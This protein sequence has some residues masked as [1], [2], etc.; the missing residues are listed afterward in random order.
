MARHSIRCE[1]LLERCAAQLE[2][3]RQRRTALS[4]FVASVERLR[5]EV[6]HDRFRRA[7][8]PVLGEIEEL[9]ERVLA[10]GGRELT[11]AQD[12]ELNAALARL[13]TLLDA[14]RREI[15]DPCRDGQSCRS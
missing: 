8:G 5:G 14:A 4:A 2:L 9:G 6:P 15:D 1:R 10:A 3:A 11:E 12:V 13:A 7:S